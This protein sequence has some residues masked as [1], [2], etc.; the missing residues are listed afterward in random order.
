MSDPK[1]RSAF[2]ERYIGIRNVDTLF[3]R[4]AQRTVK[5]KNTYPVVLDTCSKKE[6]VFIS[7][8]YIISVLKL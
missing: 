2:A 4:Y 3:R 1:A 6:F 5:K 8:Y 7:F